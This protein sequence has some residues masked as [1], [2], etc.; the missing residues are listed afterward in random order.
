MAPVQSAKPPNLAATRASFGSHCHEIGWVARVN[1][2][3]IA[4]NNLA[5]GIII[6]WLVA[7]L[8][9][10]SAGDVALMAEYLAD[11]NLTV[12]AYDLIGRRRP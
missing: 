2:L 11:A 5:N 6:A 7:P 10:G 1:R 8:V 12:A 4:L 3:A 9:S